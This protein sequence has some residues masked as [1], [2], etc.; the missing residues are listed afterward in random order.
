MP[1]VDPSAQLIGFGA[2]EAALRLQ[3]G[4]H[5]LRALE[6]AALDHELAI[7]FCRA[8]MRGSAG[9]GLPVIAFGDVKT[10]E[11]AVGEAE[12]SEDI[13]VGALGRLGVLQRGDRR[14]VFALVDQPD[15][16]QIRG[17]A[18]LGAFE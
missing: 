3:F 8:A 17:I 7:I 18:Q 12:I 13:G 5:V 2:P 16:D 15:R 14:F 6:I 10:P 9:K 4:Q 11:L 1:G